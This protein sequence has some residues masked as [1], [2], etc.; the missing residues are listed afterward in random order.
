MRFF[1]TVTAALFL[2]G[3]FAAP[4]RH[5]H[6]LHH[7]R[8]APAVTS[9]VVA[10][11]TVVVGGSSSGS[12]ISSS[13][14]VTPTSSS[15][16]TGPSSSSSSYASSSSTTSSSA[17]AP[18]STGGTSSFTDGVYDCSS[19]PSD[20]E[21]IVALDYL[22]LGGYTG[23]Q[24]GNGAGSS[25]T[26]G[27]YCSYACK[28][29]MMKTQWPSE[30]PSDGETR[31]GLVCKNGK[32]HRT[33][34]DKENL[35]EQGLGSASVENK[36]GQGVAICQTDYPGS[37]NMVI[38]TFVEGGNSSPLTVTDNNSYFHWRGMGTSAQFYVNKAG[39]SAEKGCQ[40]GTQN[41]DFGNWAPLVFGAGMTDG[42]T[43]LSIFQNPLTTQKANY[44]VKIVGENGSNVS[45]DC[46]FENGS[47]TSGS[48][49]CTVGV[50]SGSAKFVFY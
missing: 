9:Q 22:G 10:Y 2:T 29:G 7:K 26:E 16:P 35:C 11:T 6:H 18:S 3:A 32:L 47:F 46:T 15:A 33:N 49:G 38:P 17:A 13:S 45:G 12:P 41:D 31:G 24:I 14:T 36:L 25:C 34:T 50:T 44:N 1:E 5:P 42:I 8:D 30:Q 39:Y 23:I 43:W 40:W 4:F 21:G 27:A 48:N 37:E 19:F 20:Q 28:P